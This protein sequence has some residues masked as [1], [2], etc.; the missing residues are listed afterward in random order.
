MHRILATGS[1][2][3]LSLLAVKNLA[4]QS[5]NTQLATPAVP[6]SSDKGQ[7]IVLS[8]FE[9]SG[10]EVHGYQASESVTG[11]RI[12]TKIADTPFAVDVVTQN[13]MSDFMDFD[14]NSQLALVPSFSPSEVFGN[15]QLRGF[16]SPVVFVDGFKRVGL[17]DTVDIDRIEVIK[18]SAASIYGA[19]QPGGAVNIITLKPTELP[20]QSLMIGGGG[21]SYYRMSLS[22]SGP[23]GDSGKL[24]YRLDMGEYYTQFGEDFASREQ[25]SIAG[26][27]LY[28]PNA[29]T[30]VSLDLEHFELDEHPFNQVLTITEKQTMPWAGNNVTESQYYGTVFGSNLYDYDYAGPQSRN[31][32]RVTSGTLTLEHRFSDFWSMRFGAN[33]FDNPFSDQLIGSGAYYPYG[34]GNVT[35]VNGVVTNA[36]TPEVKDQPQADF[37]P[38]RGGGMQLDNTFE[39]KTGPINNRLLLTA[40]YYE[41]SQRLLTLDPSIN[42]AQGTDY[43]ATY[44]PFTPAGAPYYVMQ[45]TWNANMGY[46]WNTTT[47]A[48][49]PWMYNFA[50]TDN[51]TASTDEGLFG[52]YW[53]NLFK[54]RLT[55]MLGGRLDRVVNQVKNYNISSA[56]TVTSAGSFVEPAVYQGFDYNTEAGTYQMGAAL[57]LVK[58]VNLYANRSSAF[59]PQPQLNSYTGLPLPNNKSNGWEFGVKGDLLN[60]RLTWSLDHFWIN[61]YNVVQSETDP[62]TGIKDTILS[63]EQQAK[64]YEGEVQYQV[65]SGFQAMASWGYSPTVIKDSETLTFL[66]GLPA[67]RVPRDNGGVALRYEI[68]SGKLKGLYAIADFKYLSKSLINLG[69]GK[70]LIPGPASST[71]GG[72]ISMYYVP[73]TNRTYLTDPKVTGEDKVTATPVYNVPFPGNGLLPY[74]TVAA[75][76]LINYPVDV[77]GNPLPVLS[78][79][80][81]STV[82]SG[83]PTGVFVDDGREYIYNPCSTV[84]DVGVGYDW[85]WGKY[86]N[87][88]KLNVK[89]LFNRKY[90]W[91]SGVPGLPFEVLASYNIA[92]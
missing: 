81:N 90:T 64:G 75:N 19:I 67:R 16:A 35:V 28:K 25:S 76:A 55:L 8:P 15:F 7:V 21:Q 26:K 83:Q 60:D 48:Q 66:N 31:H 29:N 37:K 70:S 6:S 22:T 44:S 63:G 42:G 9:V 14:L 79:T 68:T 74:P 72:T 41:V 20:S 32:N 10:N 80:G 71:S 18:G 85:K 36:F 82:Y 17:V 2:A 38:Q 12:A 78:G 61:Q 84:F 57:K 30:S 11:T 58:G 4:A 23:M 49:A 13:F 91:G 5:A 1:F 24:F 46:G 34:T 86:K 27:I 52:S 92:Y 89:N 54:D 56:G 87:S 3:L 77:N 43:Y 47:Y 40:D 88:L 45:S 62:I 33:V 50:Q 65:S 53:A 59:N 51:W 73:S 69:S 39:F